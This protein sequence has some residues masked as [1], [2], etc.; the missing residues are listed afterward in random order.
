MLGKTP[1]QY[2]QLISGGRCL[3]W[4]ASICLLSDC[5][6]GCSFNDGGRFQV[7]LECSGVGDLDWRKGRGF[8]EMEVVTGQVWELVFVWFVISVWL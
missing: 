8:R 3:Q 2:S 7:G 5:C 4:R 6:E 1:S